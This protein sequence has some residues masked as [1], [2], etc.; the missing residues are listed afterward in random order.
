MSDPV[1][2][3]DPHEWWNAKTGCPWCRIKKLE[4]KVKTRDRRIVRLAKKINAFPDKLW[5]ARHER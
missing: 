4:A 5:E 1:H 2:Y 3:C